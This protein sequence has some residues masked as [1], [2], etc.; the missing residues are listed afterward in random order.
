MQ[1]WNPNQ[2]FRQVQ[3]RMFNPPYT[4]LGFQ[5]NDDPDQLRKR[6]HEAISSGNPESFV[7][8]VQ[9]EVNGWEQSHL[10]LHLVGQALKVAGQA[11]AARTCLLGALRLRKERGEPLPIASTLL[12][13]S[14]VER[15]VDNNEG[16]WAYLNEAVEV[17]PTYRS[18]HLN[19]LCLASLSHDLPHLTM[20]FHEM[21]EH[22]PDWHTDEALCK[23]LQNDGELTFLRESELW[24][25]IEV[26]MTQSIVCH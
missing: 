18:A 22:Y 15:F 21:S 10:C 9:N 3:I 12:G 8:W 1:A 16:A 19:R 2:L 7:D 25:Q 17:Y 26:E 24:Q 4:K 14:E 20:L 11:E 5:S 13:L 6:A 23:G